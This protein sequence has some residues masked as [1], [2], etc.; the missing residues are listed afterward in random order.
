M[1]DSRTHPIQVP[2]QAGASPG[3]QAD[4]QTRLGSLARAEAPP[5]EN[6]PTVDPRAAALI[7]AELLEPGETIILLLK[8]SPWFIVLGPLRMLVCLAVATVLGLALARQ[9]WLPIRSIDVLLLGIGLS[10]LRLFWQFLEWLSRIYVLTDRRV[11]RVYGVV[12]VNVFECSLKRIQHTQMSFS[13]RERV[14]G[15]GSIHFAT[16]GTAALEASWQMLAN[17]L[18]VHQI[19]IR[20]LNRYR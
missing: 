11:V 12:R 18:E 14:V 7:P 8:P 19:I 3:R 17:P 10:G 15:L 4:Q 9:G 16:A 13:L 1:V 6:Q 20:T 2:D 5:V